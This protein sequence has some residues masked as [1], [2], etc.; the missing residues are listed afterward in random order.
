MSKLGD[1][2]R[3]LNRKKKSLIIIGV[4]LT[5]LLILSA[6]VFLCVTNYIKKNFNYN[7]NEIVSE[8]EQLG[9]EEVK[10]DNVVNIALFGV[11][12]RSKNSFK[13]RSDSI[14]ILSVNTTDK[15]VKLISV[16]RDSLV[17]IEKN[18]KNTFNKINSAYASGG[19]ELAIKTLNTI[20]DL[21]ISEYATVNFSGMTEIIGAVGGIEI[22]VTDREVS[23]INEM[24]TTHYEQFGLQGEPPKV[25]SAGKHLLDGV[26]AV[27]YSRIR[28]VPNAEGTSN[29]YGRTDRQRY[30]LEQVFYKSTQMGISQYI[31][32]IK[33]LSPYCETSLSY[34]EILN[35]AVDVL[36]RSP[37]FEESRVPFIEYKMPSPNAGVG[38]IV[39]YDLNFAAKLIH[40]FIYKD[41][42]PEDY[43]AANGIEQNDWYRLGFVAPSINIEEENTQST[44]SAE[45]TVS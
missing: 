2:Y 23:M 38:S 44:E 22:E 8:P 6:T 41:I 42:K 4:I 35:L 30:V 9:F 37:T 3:S 13:G 36:L 27:A 39:Y 17:P 20:F 16:L 11:D 43:I 19:P 10:S 33:A 1:K 31:D 14:I 21:D 32:L 29:D 7:Y 5:V 40:N 45:D 26:Q 34:S 25:S 12:T 18:G 28:Y 15:K 24:V